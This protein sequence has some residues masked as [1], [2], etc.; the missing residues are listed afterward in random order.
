MK[1]R[2]ARGRR[3]LARAGFTVVEVIVAI[4]ILTVG[5]LGLA[6][7]AATVTRM[8]GSAEIESDAATIATARFETLRA[9]R[10]PV[11]SGSA[12]GAGIS[13]RWVVS[14][15]GNAAFRMYQVVDTVQYRNRRGL[16]TQAY[17]SVVQ[18]LP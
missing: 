9:T 16:R 7:T 1:R 15:M 10:C 12:S 17:R 11:A 6:S 18:C 13:E 8:M 3:P 5:V 14:Q 4:M 2:K